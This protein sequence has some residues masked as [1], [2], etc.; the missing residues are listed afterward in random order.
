MNISHHNC[1][2]GISKSSVHR[3]IELVS[4]GNE[5]KTLV[6][7]CFVYFL[8]CISYQFNEDQ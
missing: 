3:R 7:V 4:K 5:S 1:I 2:G 6:L 8:Q